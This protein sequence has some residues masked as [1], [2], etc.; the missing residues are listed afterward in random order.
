MENDK[1]PAAGSSAPAGSAIKFALE[2]RVE[3][4]INAPHGNRIRLQAIQGAYPYKR[5][6]EYLGTGASALEI[7]EAIRRIATNVLLIGPIQTAGG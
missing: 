4:R 7:D 6:T 1:T 2:N 5:K 3:L